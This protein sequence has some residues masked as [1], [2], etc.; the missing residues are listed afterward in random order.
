[1]APAPINNIQQTLSPQAAVHPPGVP[2]QSSTS[3]QSTSVSHQAQPLHSAQAPKPLDPIKAPT[4]AS[5]PTPVLAST[6][7]PP[8]KTSFGQY[9]TP[10]NP[11]SQRQPRHSETGP[12]APSML[13]P[14]QPFGPDDKNRLEKE[15]AEREAR[16]SREREKEQDRERELQKRRKAEKEAAEREALAIREREH[17]LELEKRREAEK[18]AIERE[19]QQHRE[20]E[21]EREL[22]REKRRARRAERE[23]QKELERAEQDR[24]ERAERER[25]RTLQKIE[26]EKQKEAERAYREKKE[27]ERADRERMKAER[28]RSRDVE[29]AERERARERTERERDRAT[30]AA[31]RHRSHHDK[32]YSLPANNFTG[33]ASGSDT[34]GMNKK[35]G[36][37][38]LPLS[39]IPMNLFIPS[40]PFQRTRSQSNP[41][42][43]A[44]EAQTF[45]PPPSM[46]RPGSR[47]DNAHA[48]VAIGLQSSVS[49][50]SVRNCH[51][52]P[53]QLS[54][55]FCYTY[56]II[57]PTVILFKLT[58]SIR[59]RRFCHRFNQII[60]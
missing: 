25:L 13:P 55:E 29:R 38:T 4:S 34:D 48:P 2:I 27:R 36:V 19:L 1:M 52:P 10:L 54:F 14:Y 32:N 51:L 60:P 6:S 59:W 53:D 23:R 39:R 21:R 9:Q 42:G 35:D 20:R 30:R 49:K 11:V 22:D 7:A 45:A 5:T 18:E 31:S 57:I 16:L 26:F 28:E 40:N 47:G 58:Q 37:C 17:E 8:T 44:F 43:R 3:S 24:Q 12:T 33:V 46:Q 56:R 50:P 15:A 41:S